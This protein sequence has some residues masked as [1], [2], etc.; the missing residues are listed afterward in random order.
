MLLIIS[1][2]LSLWYRLEILKTSN[3]CYW[4]TNHS[5]SFKLTAFI[6]DTHRCFHI[7]FL[8][9]EINLKAAQETFRYCSCAI[10]YIIIDNINISV[11]YQN[12]DIMII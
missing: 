3:V 11:E 9:N 4:E 12:I 2:V 10:V 7:N 6:T 5:I 8:S 1:T